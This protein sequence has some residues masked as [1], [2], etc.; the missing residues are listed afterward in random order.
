ADLLKQQDQLDQKR[1]AAYA[2]LARFNP[3]KDSKRIAELQDEL[4]RY[5]IQQR[6]L[7]AEFRRTSPRLANL[8][9]PEPL[10]L[11]AAQA[12]LDEGTLLLA[13]CVDE[14]Q[15]Y[16]FAVTKTSFKLITLPIAEAEL[17][18]QVVAFYKAVAVLPPRKLMTSAHQAGQNL[19]TTLVSP[20]RELVDQA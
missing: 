9:Y 15:T 3:E 19:Y 12:A 5:S 18:K 17:K 6:E 20:A 11:P 2:A 13:Y 4:T 8:R 14:K 16:L 10:D 1:S 7:E